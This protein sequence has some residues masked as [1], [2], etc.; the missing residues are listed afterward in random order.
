MPALAAKKLVPLPPT[1]RLLEAV[2]SPR[3]DTIK[4]T[5]QGAAQGWTETRKR[6]PDFNTAVLAAQSKPVSTVAGL[7]NP[8]NAY[9]RNRAYGVAERASP[10]LSDIEYTFLPEVRRA[11]AMQ[12]LQGQYGAT[13]QRLST[14]LGNSGQE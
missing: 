3:Y 6:D 7:L 8:L 11:L 1:D 9:T 13:K 2:S 10:L 5:A 12:A 4:Q 14:A